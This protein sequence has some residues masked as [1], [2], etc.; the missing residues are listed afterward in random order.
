MRW[1]TAFAHY[2]NASE[3]LRNENDERRAQGLFTAGRET[4]GDAAQTAELLAR[5]ERLRG[6]A[7]RVIAA[8]D[9]DAQITVD[10]DPLAG[11]PLPP[12]GQYD[13][14]PLGFFAGSVDPRELYFETIV[15]PLDG[16][17]ARSACP[18]WPS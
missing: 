13:I 3:W 8:W 1:A 18:R 5:E 11:D 10:V 16:T 9:S 6:L 15:V 12:A 2:R 4:F 14:V 17:R 7:E